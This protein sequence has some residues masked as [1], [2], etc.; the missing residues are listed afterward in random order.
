VSC[1]EGGSLS[2]TDWS[3]RRR[4]VS[5]RS[6]S[7]SGAGPN[8]SSPFVVLKVCGL[9][10]V[11]AD[12]LA[13]GISEERSPVDSSHVL[14]VTDVVWAAVTVVDLSVISRYKGQRLRITVEAQMVVDDPHDT[15]TASFSTF[16]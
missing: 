11:E 10:K 2:R 7:G 13:W 9:V 12:P 6:S 14:G 15:R 16:A 4:S 3:L 1:C 5:I 8:F